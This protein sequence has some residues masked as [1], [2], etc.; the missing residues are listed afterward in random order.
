M[1]FIAACLAI[2]F[3]L[4][5]HS[6]FTRP[7]RGGRGNVIVTH[8]CNIFTAHYVLFPHVASS[9]HAVSLASELPRRFYRS[10]Y[11]PRLKEN[12]ESRMQLKLAPEKQGYLSSGSQRT[13]IL[14]RL[15]EKLIFF[16]SPYP[17]NLFLF[18]FILICNI[19]ALYIE[20]YV[21]P[22]KKTRS[23]KYTKLL[24]RS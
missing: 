23:Q 22:K 12:E 15:I 13:G 17:T 14:H 10:P 19:F 16:Y 18:L 7:C 8:V 5:R 4:P 9:Y 21:A 24:S 20:Q 6:T 11:F 3:A 2:N 1:K